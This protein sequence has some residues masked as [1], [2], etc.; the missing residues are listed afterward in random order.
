LEFAEKAESRGDPGFCC[1]AGILRGF[2]EKAVVRCGFLLV[3][4]WWFVWW[5]WWLTGVFLEGEKYATFLMNFCGYFDFLFEGRS[6]RPRQEG[7][8]QGL[9]PHSRWRGGRPKAKALDYLR[10]KN[11]GVVRSGSFRVAKNERGDS[12]E[13]VWRWV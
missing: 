8:P 1:F 4:C 11:L 7:I 5:A 9:K 10:S 2:W 13:T 6:S 3:S 12:L